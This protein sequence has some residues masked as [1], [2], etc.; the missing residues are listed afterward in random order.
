MGTVENVGR[1]QTPSK[2]I[3]V[4]RQFQSVVVH[5]YPA[6]EIFEQGFCFWCVIDVDGFIVCDIKHTSL[7]RFGV[8]RDV[9]VLEDP[10]QNVLRT[11]A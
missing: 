2:Q 7:V 1:G 6:Q 8:F 4:D 3:V 11:R 10:Q 9:T 5:L